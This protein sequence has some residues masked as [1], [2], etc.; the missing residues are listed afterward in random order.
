MVFSLGFEIHPMCFL[1][2]VVTAELEHLSICPN[3]GTPSFAPFM[4]MRVPGH[5]EQPTAFLSRTNRAHI[6]KIDLM[7]YFAEICNAVVSLIPIDV[8]DITAGEESV[9]HQPDN[10][11]DKVVSSLKAE[12][13]IAASVRAPNLVFAPLE[14]PGEWVVLEILGQVIHRPIIPWLRHKLIL[15]PISSAGVC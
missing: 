2:G 8:V 11:V 4:L 13:S 6:L 14:N 7:R 5:T 3:I 1:R 12:S 9:K 10:S 15:K